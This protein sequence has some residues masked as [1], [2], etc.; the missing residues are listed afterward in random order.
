MY[1]RTVRGPMTILKELWS[2][3]VPDDEIKTTYHYV[4]DLQERLNSTCDIARKA[5]T[6]AFAKYKRHFDVRAKERRFECGDRVLLL[7][8]TSTNKLVTQW[9]GLDEVVRRI[10]RNDYKLML[11]GKEKTY[12]ANLLKRYVERTD[13]TGTGNNVTNVQGNLMSWSRRKTTTGR[14]ELQFRR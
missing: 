3:T 8:P 4:I 2:S 7:L 12:H 9:R 11:D 10:A 6:K 1:G 5:L 13:S 14:L